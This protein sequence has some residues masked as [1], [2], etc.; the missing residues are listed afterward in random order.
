MERLW[1]PGTRLGDL[2][3]LLSRSTPSAFAHQNRED[4]LRTP[5]EVLGGSKGR[6][7][8]APTMQDIFDLLMAERRVRQSGY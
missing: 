7:A 8:P 1:Y 6:L 5:A 3:G 2:G 4:G